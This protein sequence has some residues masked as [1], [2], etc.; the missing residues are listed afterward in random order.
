[1]IKET[2]ETSSSASFCDIYL[3]FDNKCQL[4]IRRYDKGEDFNIAII[5]VPHIASNI[6]NTRANGVH[7]SQ[8]ICYAR[9]CSLFSDCL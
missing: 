1:V 8:L 5:N 2:T 3:K 6:P 9:S 4:S 7:V